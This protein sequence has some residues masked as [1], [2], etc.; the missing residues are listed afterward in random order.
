MRKGEEVQINTQNS[1]LKNLEKEEQNKHNISK[2]GNN[3]AKRKISGIEH[4]KNR[5]KSMKL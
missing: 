1:H 5:K 2:R 4:R 3:E